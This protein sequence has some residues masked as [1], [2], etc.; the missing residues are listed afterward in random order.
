[1]PTSC[2]KS[3]KVNHNYVVCENLAVHEGAL[4]AP[5]PALHH[6]MLPAPFFSSMKA[7]KKKQNQF[8]L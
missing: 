5:S 7:R 6:S 4:Q 3:S 1:M 8:Q 2:R